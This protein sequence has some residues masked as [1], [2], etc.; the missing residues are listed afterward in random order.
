L[1]LMLTPTAPLVAEAAGTGPSIITLHASGMSSRQWARFVRDASPR[2][3]VFSADLLG[4]GRTALGDAPYS[5]AREAE[6]LLALI[7]R[8]DGPVSLLAHSF[9]GLVAMEAAVRAPTKIKS[10]ALFEP[11]IVV[12]AREAESPEARA[13][14]A[15]INT[16]MARDVRDGY[17]HW[18]E[19][20][21]DW[22]NGPGFFQTLPVP[23]RDQYLATAH[24]A[25]RQAR[26][27]PTS[28]LTVEALRHLS[29]PTLF[30]TGTSSPATARESAQIAADAMPHGRI[31]RVEGAGHMAPLTHG[32][33]VNSAVLAFFD[34]VYDRRS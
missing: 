17:A 30:L 18:L 9:G 1:T 28:T 4:V 21:I 8:M 20:F 19:G 10:M 13:Q 7:D 34:A 16:L 24:E 32:S 27:V 26:V 23:T 22:W 11:V 25:H 12:L 31:Q 2:Y 33:I 15:A 3:R 5:L 14:I 29:I 6:A